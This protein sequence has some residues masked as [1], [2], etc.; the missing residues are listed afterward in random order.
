MNE[1]LL[2][3]AHERLGATFTEVSGMEVV[4]RY[5]AASGE[6][7]ALT[8]STG[9]LDLSFRGRLC[10]TGA[11]RVKFLHGQV[12]NDVNR[13]AAGAGCYAALITAKGRMQS[14]L[15]VYRLED[16]VLL[17]FEPGLSAAVAQRL[18]KYIISEDVQVIDVS[19]PYGVL[20]VQGPAS[21]KVLSGLSIATALPDKPFRFVKVT[22]SEGEV[23]IVNRARFGP[24]GFD[25]FLPALLLQPWF[26]NLLKICGDAGGGPCG[27]DAC[28]VA[29]IEAGIPRYGA[30]MDEANIPL[31]AGLENIA[32]SFSKGC[33]IGQEVIS[34]IKTYSEVQKALRLIQL[35]RDLPSLPA[36]GTKLFKAGKEVGYITSATHSP[37]TESNIAFAYVRKEC[38][39]IGEKV[40]VGSESLE[41]NAVIIQ[42]PFEK[43]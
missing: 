28:E 2:H 10:V 12:T 30:D 5:G 34:R 7:K 1:L 37:K 40:S 42:R 6:Y 9:L 41:P 27:W 29:R 33:Y 43:L 4:A 18:E 3:A 16:E 25:L 13:L 15:N 14:D 39:E 17:D 19:A 8:E 36:K 20:S 22:H 24:L 32:I 38:N 26:E 11:D 23:Y 31:E 21:A 35:P